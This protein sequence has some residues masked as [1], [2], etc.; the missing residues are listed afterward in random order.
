MLIILHLY[1]LLFNRI[2]LRN[3]LIN[4]PLIL[5]ILVLTSL[6]PSFLL[7]RS[8]TLC[9]HGHVTVL[10]AVYSQLTHTDLR[11]EVLTARVRFM[12]QQPQIQTVNIHHNSLLLPHM[13]ILILIELQIPI[14]VK[15]ILLLRCPYRYVVKQINLRRDLT[16]IGYQLYLFYAR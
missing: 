11:K 4:I 5:Y 14:F 6:L 9:L 8:V 10:S 7:Y 15:P 12:K 13:T 16:M 3:P 1:S 2:Q